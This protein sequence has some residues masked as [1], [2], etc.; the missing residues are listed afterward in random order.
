M[1]TLTRLR[2]PL[3]CGM[4]FLSTQAMA[5]TTVYRCGNSYSQTPCPQ[6]QTLQVDDSRDAAQRQQAQAN[7]QRQAQQAQGL[8]K[9]RVKQEQAMAKATAQ[10]QAQA[11][12]AQAS[13]PAPQPPAPVVIKPQRK[14]PADKKKDEFVAAVPGAHKPGTSGKK[15]E[16][17]TNTR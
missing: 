15:A 4:L 8:E 16:N 11:A 10:A 12:R 2:L 17:T 9:Q 5:Q 7:T 6:G 14:K 13:K 1:P 3:L